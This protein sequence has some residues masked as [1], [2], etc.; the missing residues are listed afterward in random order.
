MYKKS[1]QNMILGNKV[2]IILLLSYNCNRR[3]GTQVEG[4]DPSQVRTFS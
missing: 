4:P 1:L 3:D 2:V